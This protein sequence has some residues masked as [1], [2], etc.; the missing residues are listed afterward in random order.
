M[1]RHLAMDTDDL[2]LIEHPRRISRALAL[3]VAAAGAGLCIMILSALSNAQ[4]G[5]YDDGE[6]TR[7]G[8]IA[9][10]VITLACGGI[11]ALLWTTAARVRID[12]EGGSVTSDLRFLGFSWTRSAPITDDAVVMHREIQVSTGHGSQPVNVVEFVAGDRS[13]EVNRL[14]DAHR[15]RAFAERVAAYMSLPLVDAAEGTLSLREPGD[16]DR[17]VVEQ[18]FASSLT[19]PQSRISRRVRWAEAGDGVELEIAPPGFGNGSAV[20]VALALIAVWIELRVLGAVSSGPDGPGIAFAVMVSA[21]LALLVW[22]GLWLVW[23]TTFHT[24]RC[25]VGPRGLRTSRSTSGL[26]PSAEIE[27]VLA[28]DGF[29]SVR[30]DARNVRLGQ[31]LSEEEVQDVRAVVLLALASDPAHAG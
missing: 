18:G 13:V 6:R 24:Q 29:V 3:V 28:G 20:G 30:S 31:G 26:V 11:A 16:L 9:V 10:V 27:E 2:A 5:A 23:S 1:D 19:W 12:L 8:A 4:P 25:N 7:V 21:F 15:A 17:S 14:P 22:I